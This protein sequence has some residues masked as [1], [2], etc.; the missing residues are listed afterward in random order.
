MPA[1]GALHREAQRR[2]DGAG[3]RPELRLTKRANCIRLCSVKRSYGAQ[4]R[5]ERIKSP[6]C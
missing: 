1:G 3:F 4:A 6:L 5:T 2:T